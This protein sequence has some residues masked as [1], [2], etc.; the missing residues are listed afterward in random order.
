M[1]AFNKVVRYSLKKRKGSLLWVLGSAIFIYAGIQLIYLHNDYSPLQLL[2][3][4]EN[5]ASRLLRFMGQIQVQCNNSLPTNNAS[6]WML[7]QESEFGI[8]FSD[9]EKETSVPLIYSIGPTYD[10]NFE[11][12]VSKNISTKLYVFSHSADKLNFFSKINPSGTIVVKSVIVPNDPAD[13]A[14]NSYETQTLNSAMLNLKHTKIDVLKI[15]TLVESVTSY[16]FLKFLIEDGVLANVKEL[17]I[18][19]KL[20]KLE[21]DYIYSWYRAL[22]ALFHTAGFRLYHTAT[23]ETLCL[24][25]TMMESCK[26]YLSWIRDIPPHIFVMYPP[27]IDGSFQHEKERIENYLGITAKENMFQPVKFKLALPSHQKSVRDGSKHHHMLLDL[28]KLLL[29]NNA[30][31]CNIIFILDIQYKDLIFH[32]S[33]RNAGCK[34]HKLVLAPVDPTSQN[35][36][37]FALISENSTKSD[38]VSLSH[39]QQILKRSATSIMYIELFDA[40]DFIDSMSREGLPKLLHQLIIRTSFVSSGYGSLAGLLRR[41]YSEL[42]QIEAF[43]LELVS[44]DKTVQLQNGGQREEHILNFVQKTFT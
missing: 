4:V 6:M 14:R 33:H 22:Y 15:D 36:E 39:V 26:Y 16:E 35:F 28:S 32:A 17:H 23:S 10:Y 37:F 41:R 9:N 42:Q 25:D 20:D 40:W 12:F 29:S 13:F 27:A 34:S 2:S 44:S 21:E 38:L 8:K 24:E 43:Q 19:I 7:C 11:Y 5:E 18:V 3:S 1:K 31:P 30:Q